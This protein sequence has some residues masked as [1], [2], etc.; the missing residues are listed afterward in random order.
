M[1]PVWKLY[2]TKKKQKKKLLVGDRRAIQKAEKITGKKFDRNHNE[3]LLRVCTKNY[4]RVS[5]IKEVMSMDWPHTSYYDSLQFRHFEY[6]VKNIDLIML[7]LRV[8]KA[9]MDSFKKK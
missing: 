9:N 6:V 7:I 8:T 1:G 2:F 4:D 5:R 3:A